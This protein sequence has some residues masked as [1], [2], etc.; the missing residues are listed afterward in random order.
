MNAG[1]SIPMESKA[2]KGGSIVL[3]RIQSKRI[4]FLVILAAAAVC[5][6][7]LAKVFAD[8]PGSASDP[9]VTQSFLSQ[10]Y[11]W[12]LTYLSRGESISLHLG[13]EVVLRSGEAVF[14]GKN[15]HGIAD[16]TIGRNLQS[17]T[18]I[19]PNHLLICPFS[20][21]NRIQAET[22]TLLLSKGELQ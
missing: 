8:Q 21:G 6:F 5:V 14:F 1:V 15:S 3:N 16:L 13:T 19:P 11:S 9:I 18:L 22:D 20:K 2:I 17:G 4:N 10:N 7:L 12:Q